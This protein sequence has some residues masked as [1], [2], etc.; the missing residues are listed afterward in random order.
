MNLKALFLIVTIVTTV[1][2]VEILSVSAPVQAHHSG[3]HHG[4]HGHCHN[5]HHGGGGGGDGGTPRPR[6]H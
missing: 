1:A 2:A 5:G 4:G 6:P 3:S